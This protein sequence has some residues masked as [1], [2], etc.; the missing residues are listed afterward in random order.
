MYNTPVRFWLEMSGSLG[1]VAFILYRVGIFVCGFWKHECINGGMI[2]EAYRQN[3]LDRNG[4]NG[5]YPHVECF[6]T[7]DSNLVMVTSGLTK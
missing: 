4:F 1:T 3:Q 2:H 6:E 7:N 5:E